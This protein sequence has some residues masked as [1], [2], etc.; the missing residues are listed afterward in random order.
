MMQALSFI[1]CM[2]YHLCT[3]F[4]I[5]SSSL[6]DVFNTLANQKLKSF[7]QERW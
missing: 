3:V 6:H 7:H 4:A 5:F 1:L 2:Y